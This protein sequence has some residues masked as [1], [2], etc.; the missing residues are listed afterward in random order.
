MSS[1]ELIGESIIENQT[2]GIRT[3]I[4]VLS[5]SITAS[6]KPTKAAQ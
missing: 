3:M 4:P 2:M 6:T 1:E 5:K